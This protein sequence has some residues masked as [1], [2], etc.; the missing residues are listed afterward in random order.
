MGCI[1]V[2]GDGL[3]PVAVRVGDQEG[4]SGAHAPDSHANRSKG[5][6]MEILLS[7]RDHWLRVVC[8]RIPIEASQ[9][10]R[11][12]AGSCSDLMSATHS[13]IN[14]ATRPAIDWGVSL[15]IN[16]SGNR[17]PRRST[18]GFRRDNG[19]AIVGSCRAFVLFSRDQGLF[20]ARL[21]ALCRRIEECIQQRRHRQKETELRQRITGIHR[22]THQANRG[23]ALLR[24]G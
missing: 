16:H 15:R 13:E 7:G 3:K 23:Q 21:I 24:C 8:L 4:N 1:A 17:S 20:T 9:G 12:E 2:P 5:I 18:R 14:P 22:V 6:P 11:G 19:A 10:F